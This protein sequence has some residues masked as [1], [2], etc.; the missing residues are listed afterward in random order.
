MKGKAV[1]LIP[2]EPSTLVS[3]IKALKGDSSRDA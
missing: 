1:D 3:A 2:G